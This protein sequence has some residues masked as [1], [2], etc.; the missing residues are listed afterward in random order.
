MEAFKA[1]GGSA[2]SE[3]EE[4][5]QIEGIP[6]LP[7]AERSATLEEMTEEEEKA[8]ERNRKEAREVYKEKAEAFRRGPKKPLA[9]LRANEE[10]LEAR[11]TMDLLPHHPKE[12][13][14]HRR[15]RQHQVVQTVGSD[16]SNHHTKELKADTVRLLNSFRSS[17]PIEAVIDGLIVASSNVAMTML[18][19]SV[20]TTDAKAGACV[21]S[22]TKL[23]QATTDLM[24][25][26]DQRARGPQSVTLNA[27]KV[28]AGGQAI[29]GNV[30]SCKEPRD[31]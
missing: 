3:D 4:T 21:A 22:A 1:G 30:Q 11:A 18:A 23:V 17:D 9:V 16:L 19:R 26:R 29:V 12:A 31:G 15:L 24:K 25:Y 13:V 5:E 8:L 20:Q 10:Q 27:V 28:E 6:S 7:E 2:P 14:P